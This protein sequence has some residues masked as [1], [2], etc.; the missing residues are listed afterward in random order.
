[1]VQII[2]QRQ[3]L[4]P[5]KNEKADQ[6]I[7]MGSQLMGQIGQNQQAN[8]QYQQENEAIKSLTGMDPSGIRDPKMRQRLLDLSLQGQ[9][10][11]KMQQFKIQQEQAQQKSL[12]NQQ[13]IVGKVLRGEKVTPEE[14]DS[15]PPNVQLALDKAT[16][17]KAA[18]GGISG[19]PVPQ[20]VSQ[21]ISPILAANKNA[22]SDELAE[23]FD[24]AGIPRAFSNSYIENRRRQDESIARSDV[25]KG[26]MTR[27]EETE[28][29]KPILLEMNQS[30]KNIP[31]QEQAIEDIKNAT[32]EVGS[33][34]Y[35]AE[36]TGFEPARTASGAKLKTAI[37]DFFLSDLTRAGAR[38]NMWIEQQL[39]D[40]LPKIGRSKE[41]NLITAEG[42]QFK[43]D[44]AKKRIDI[45]DELAEQDKKKFG[46]VKGDID[47][48]ASKL[49]KP[50]VEQRKKD[51]QES[52]K[53]IKNE[54]PDE[55][56]PS[57]RM[58]SP[59]GE[60][61]DIQPSDVEEAEANGF[62]YG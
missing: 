26:K 45:I 54:K 13:I 23:A 11:S 33:L 43:V 6:F 47:S 44:L 18:P 41:A 19:Q 9:Q 38:P 62:K 21:A 14:R 61:W 31:L 51:L 7:N 17:P 40:A 58:L 22:T 37:K 16:G 49:M 12:Q 34:D 32:P 24:S 5:T 20:E 36:V 35:F 25:E 55:E 53:K 60:I 46:Y 27:Q 3:K 48:R 56:K 1:M 57:V 10:E 8:Q 2:A 52:I 30:R 15:L 39:A 28:I 42:M 4:G 50:Y 59:E 29:S